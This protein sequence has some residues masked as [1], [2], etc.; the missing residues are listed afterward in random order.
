MNIV[1]A[2]LDEMFNDERL[3]YTNRYEQ[4]EMYKYFFNRNIFMNRG[5]I[6]TEVYM[7]GA[8]KI[9]A[10]RKL[11]R[12][13]TEEIKK[14]YN[15]EF[16]DAIWLELYENE[17]NVYYAVITSE[18]IYKRARI[19]K[20]TH[21]LES[22][23][24]KNYGT[25]NQEYKTKKL[26]YSHYTFDRDEDLGISEHV[27]VC[28]ANGYFDNFSIDDLAIITV[29]H[30]NRDHYD[31][32]PCNLELTDMQGQVDHKIVSDILKTNGVLRSIDVKHCRLFKRLSDYYKD[33]YI[34]LLKLD[35]DKNSSEWFNNEVMDNFVSKLYPAVV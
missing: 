16:E 26:H 23:I 5:R 12:Y 24:A 35:I 17:N 4:I 10:L 18:G 22:G 32:R 21:K 11:P 8:F 30:K 19:N 14:V 7:V 25:T 33:M 1:Y 27:L 6:I 28:I 13:S 31:N 29:N 3:A 9:D 34:K 2:S 20:N 15:I